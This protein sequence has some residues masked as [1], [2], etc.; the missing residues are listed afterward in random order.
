[1]NELLGVE[2]ED[3]SGAGEGYTSPSGEGTSQEPVA[4]DNSANNLYNK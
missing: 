4:K 3:S 2:E 1:L